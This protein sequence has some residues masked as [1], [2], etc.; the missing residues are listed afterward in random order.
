M[1]KTMSKFAQVSLVDYILKLRPDFDPRVNDKINVSSANVLYSLWKTNKDA[2]GK[3]IKTTKG[4]H[5]DQIKTLES[6]NLIKREGSSLIVTPKGEKI[7]RVMVLGD[8][9]SVF[10]DNSQDIDYKTAL[11]NTKNIKRGKIKPE[12]IFWDRLGI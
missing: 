4:L 12:D 1:K 2:S 8:D 6:E 11:N 3:E 9:R 7:I 10:D 5:E